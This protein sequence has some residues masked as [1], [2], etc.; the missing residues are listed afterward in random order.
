MAWGDPI[1]DKADL[2][3][4][5]PLDPVDTLAR[6]IY[7]EARGESQTGKAGVVW[8]VSNRVDKNRIEFGGNTYKGVCLRQGAFDGMKTLAARQPDTSSQ[9]WKD[10]IK[11]A[12]AESRSSNPIGKC[13]WFVTNTL[14]SS[15]VK[16]INGSEY[17][18]F[19]TGDKK[20]VEKVVIGNHTF[21]RVEGY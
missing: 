14:F 15:K 10:C 7:S 21:F 5:D 12:L 9:A 19:G 16:K 8:V 4:F 17:W 11:E 13:L 20:L 18:N 6:L 3:E 1:Q 2:T